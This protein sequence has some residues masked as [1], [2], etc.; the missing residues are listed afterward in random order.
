MDCIFCKIVNKE[1]PAWLVAETEDYLAFLDIKPVQPGHT[2]VIPKKH[3][4]DLLSL[5]EES[6]VGLIKFAKIVAKA[7]VKGTASSGF[8]LTLNNGVTAG[9]VINH[10]HFHIIPRLAHDQLPAWPHKDY[11]I[12]Q[13]EDLSVKIA[14]YFKEL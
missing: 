14:A 10:C 2:L 4:E 12:N 11:Q 13:A 7:V 9:Q 1:L 3:Y 6:A 5:P 8:N